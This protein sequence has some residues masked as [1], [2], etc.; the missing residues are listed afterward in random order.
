LIGRRTDHPRVKQILES[1]VAASAALL[2][3]TGVSLAR[4]SLN[5]P[6]AIFIAGATVILMITKK[7]DSLVIIA[8][9]ALLALVASV[10]RPPI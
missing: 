8:A 9:S 2:F 10:L 3:A 7:A 5:E 4:E 1:V 6:V